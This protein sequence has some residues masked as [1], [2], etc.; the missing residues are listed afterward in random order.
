[1]SVLVSPEDFVPQATM[2]GRSIERPHKVDGHLVYAIGDI[3]GCYR[4][5]TAL[6]QMIAEDAAM[7]AAGRNTI[8]IFCGDYVDRGPDSSKVLDS[9]CWLR[10]HSPYELYFLKGNHE[11]VFNAYLRDPRQATEWLKFGG[12][13]TMA[14]YGVTPPAEDAPPADHYRARDDLLEAMPVSHWRFLERLELMVTIGDYAFVHAGV[15]ANLPLEQQTE[16]D[17]LWIR[18]GFLDFNGSHEKIVVHGHSWDSYDPDIQDNRI[19]IDTGTYESG[20]L[21]ALRVEDGSIGVLQATA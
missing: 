9:L 14:S 13:E 11:E 7:R 8:L 12:C 3:H 18:D 10:R 1:M 6:F 16:E 15:R 19:G 20:I 5:L 2:H 17:L 21:T 4:Q